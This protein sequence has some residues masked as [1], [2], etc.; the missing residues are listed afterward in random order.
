MLKGISVQVLILVVIGGVDKIVIFSRNDESVGRGYDRQ[1][2]TLR[3]PDIDNSIF[4]CIEVPAI[5]VSQILCRIPVTIDA[6]I[7][8]GSDCPMIGGDNYSHILGSELSQHTQ[9]RGVL[10]PRLS[11]R[12]ESRSVW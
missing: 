3:I 2:I 1:L 6:G 7:S 12:P 11:Q 9:K 8:H 5:F 4:I 10:K